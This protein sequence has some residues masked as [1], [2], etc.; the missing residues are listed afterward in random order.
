MKHKSRTKRATTNNSNQDLKIKGRKLGTFKSPPPQRLN[1]MLRA[2]NRQENRQDINN[3][4]D[5]SLSYDEPD[6]CNDYISM[7]QDKTD[8]FSISFPR[9][10]VFGHVL[11]DTNPLDIMDSWKEVLRYKVAECMIRSR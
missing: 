2:I 11:S 9:H 3:K 10:C 8:R 4:E 6:L 7:E 1:R 5:Y